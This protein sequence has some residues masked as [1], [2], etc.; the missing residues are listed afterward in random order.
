M[1][2]WTSVDAVAV[3]SSTRDEE[4]CPP[5]RTSTAPLIAAAGT[6]TVSEVAVEP[7]PAT[8]STVPVAVAKTTVEAEVNPVPVNV[9]T[10]PRATLAG[11]IDV[12]ARGAGGV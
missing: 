12:S 1:E 5:L 11:E 2:D 4:L 9:S 7:L 8:A 6:V 10:P 3:T